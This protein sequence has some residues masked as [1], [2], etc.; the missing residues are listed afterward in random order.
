MSGTREVRAACRAAQRC[1]CEALGFDTWRAGALCVPPLRPSRPLAAAFHGEWPEVTDL[2]QLLKEKPLSMSSAHGPL[3]AKE[4]LCGAGCCLPI[5]ARGPSGRS[6]WLV[7]VSAWAASLVPRPS[8]G[9]DGLW[10]WPSCGP[11]L[12]WPMCSRRRQSCWVPAAVAP[13]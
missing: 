8:A 5:R 12:E 13:V 11:H 7:C 4:T 10:R 9:T 6:G 3:P 2:C 1:L